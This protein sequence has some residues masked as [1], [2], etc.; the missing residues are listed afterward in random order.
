MNSLEVSWIKRCVFSV[1]KLS[2]R[3]MPRDSNTLW[4]GT[5]RFCTAHFC[6]SASLMY[7]FKLS[8]ESPLNLAGVSWNCCRIHGI[9]R[10]SVKI[11]AS[12]FLPPSVKDKWV[13]DWSGVT[14]CP[15]HR[16]ILFLSI[17]V[18]LHVIQKPPSSPLG[19]LKSV[20]HGLESIQHMPQNSQ[21]TTMI[22]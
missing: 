15:V 19:L 5:L 7:V 3:R 6:L 16:R 2:L 20:V 8:C 18:P 17:H 4:Q 14:V 22:S 1:V 21:S 10:L 9:L 13:W 11:C 12:L